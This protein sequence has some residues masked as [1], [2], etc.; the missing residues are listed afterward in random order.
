MLGNFAVG[1]ISKLLTLI[2]VNVGAIV[3]CSMGQ[4]DSQAVVALMGASMGYVFGNGHGI[5]S[6]SKAITDTQ[7]GKKSNE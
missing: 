6:A 3:L 1:E 2:L 7:K 4:M 5:I